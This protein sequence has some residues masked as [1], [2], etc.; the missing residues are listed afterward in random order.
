MLILGGYFWGVIVY[1]SLLIILG[2]NLVII[3]YGNCI[4]LF[5]VLKVL[6]I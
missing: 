4:D 3:V 5:Y 2:L 1:E 6:I